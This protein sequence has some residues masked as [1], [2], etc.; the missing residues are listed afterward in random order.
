MFLTTLIILLLLETTRTPLTLTPRYRGN[1]VCDDKNAKNYI[2]DKN[3]QR[4]E[5]LFNKEKTQQNSEKSRKKVKKMQPKNWGQ[6]HSPEFRMKKNT[7]IDTRKSGKNTKIYT[8]KHQN[9]H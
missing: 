8:K 9:M 4:G 3:L 7:T 2:G 1:A 5:V 6:F